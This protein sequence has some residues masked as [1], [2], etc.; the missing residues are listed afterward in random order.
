MLNLG[1]RMN[2]HTANSEGGSAPILTGVTTHIPLELGA[3]TQYQESDLSI[4]EP[5]QREIPTSG[6]DIKYP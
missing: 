2:C 5:T 4:V 6:L 3:F 1:A